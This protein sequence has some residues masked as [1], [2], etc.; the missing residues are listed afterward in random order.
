[1]SSEFY[2]SYYGT[3]YMVTLRVTKVKLS[4]MYKKH[5]DFLLLY[6]PGYNPWFPIVGF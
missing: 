4:G 1:M 6:I 2:V 5:P 3:S